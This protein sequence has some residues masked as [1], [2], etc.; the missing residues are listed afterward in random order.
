M[1]RTET[2]LIIILAM[3]LVA[4]MSF[5]GYLMFKICNDGKKTEGGGEKTKNN[6]SATVDVGSPFHTDFFNQSAQHAE[7]V[8]FNKVFIQEYGDPNYYGNSLMDVL[9][10]LNDESKKSIVTA[11]KFMSIEP[12]SARVN[13]KTYRMVAEQE[14]VPVWFV[15]LREATMKVVPQLASSEDS[16]AK[17]NIVPIYQRAG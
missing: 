2:I 6:E 4:Y 5:I 14:R 13:E 12:Q 16:G 9:H 3:I 11:M 17:D 15:I 10:K 8:L 7:S 1:S